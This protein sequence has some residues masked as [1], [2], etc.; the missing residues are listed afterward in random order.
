VFRTVL[1][2]WAALTAAHAGP[3]SIEPDQSDRLRLGEGKSYRFYALVEGDSAAVVELVPPAVPGWSL[4]LRDS[5]GTDLLLDTDS[6][7]IPDLGRVLPGVKRWFSLE[8]R[9]PSAPVGDT[10]SLSERTIIVRG[11]VSAE[12]AAA[13]SALI[14]VA[15]VPDFSVHNFPNPLVLR[16]TFVISLPDDGK[17]SL[18]IYTRAGERVCRV[19]QNEDR[20]AGIHLVRWEAVNDQGQDVAPGTYEYVLDYV[21]RGETDRIRKRLVVTR[22]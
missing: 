8:V 11:R 17:V 6:D 19:T 21:H 13:D 15:L 3:L 12:P 4:Q 1:A 5:A 2:A 22:E 16:T 20:S 7:G 9:A 14:T 18:T 10:A